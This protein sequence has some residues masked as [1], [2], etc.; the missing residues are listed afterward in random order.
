M[1]NAMLNDVPSSVQ[2]TPFVPAVESPH[3]PDVIRQAERKLAEIESLWH[4]M[5]ID[6]ERPDLHLG[7]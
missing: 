2:F 6:E 3:A 5:E 7:W 4:L 1:S